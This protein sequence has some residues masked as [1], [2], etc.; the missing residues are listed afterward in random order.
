MDDQKDKLLK[1]NIPV[2]A[3]HGNN[4]NKD[5]E[6]FEIID[7]KIKIIYMSPEYLIKGDG[8]ELA[9]SMIANNLLGFLA[10][11]ESHCISVWGHDFSLYLIR[12]RMQVLLLV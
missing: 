5:R 9:D 1:K 2:S 10:V 6:L 3:L 11:D 8:F 7:G 4:K 12:M